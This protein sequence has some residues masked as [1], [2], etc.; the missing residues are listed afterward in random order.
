MR[1]LFERRNVVQDVNTATISGNHQVMKVALYYR[2]GEGGMRQTFLERRPAGAVVKRV[3]K[4]VAGAGEEQAL[5][6]GILGN[7]PDVAQ[8][9]LGQPGADEFPGASEIRGLV[10][11]RI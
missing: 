5:L 10:D 3:E 7:H 2:P 11:V 8:R 6:V 1:H 9:F 4:A